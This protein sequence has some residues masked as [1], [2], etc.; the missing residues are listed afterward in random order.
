M[1]KIQ[2]PT[3]LIVLV[4][5]L[6]FAMFTGVNLFAQGQTSPTPTITATPTNHP[7]SSP[8]GTHNPTATPTASPLPTHAPTSS[9]TAGPTGT[10]TIAPTHMPTVSPLVPGEINWNVWGWVLGGLVALL[11]LLLIAWAV[12]RSRHDHYRHP[13]QDIHGRISSEDASD[14]H[15]YTTGTTR[16]AYSDDLTN[17]SCH[18]KDT[19]EKRIKTETNRFH[20]DDL[21]RRLY[22]EDNENS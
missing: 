14:T 19:V 16:R 7:T 18:P 8:T 22:P 1:V 13:A 10:P 12:Y 20:P 21:N 3:V 2:K 15:T 6:L 17:R 9:S 11:A 5:F 4:T